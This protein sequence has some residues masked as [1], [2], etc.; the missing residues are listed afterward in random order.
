[1]IKQETSKPIS[2]SMSAFSMGKDAL[3]DR[4]VLV[5]GA[6]GGLGTEL[7]LACAR[8]GATVVLVSK[9]LYKQE[10]LYDAIE[11]IEGAPQPAIITINQA[12][13]PEEDYAQMNEILTSEFGHLDALVHTAA[14]VGPLSPL[15][16]IAQA[17][18]SRVMSVNLTSTRLLTNAC[19]PLL[20]LSSNASITFTMDEKSS[21]YWGAYGVSKMGLFALAS[22]VHDETENQ[23]ADDGAAQ[24][25]IN[26]IDPGPMRTPL[27]R[28]AFPGELETES[29]TPESKLGPFLALIARENRQLNGSYLKHP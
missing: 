29:P 10:L 25:A 15:T 20:N 7:C 2:D 17:D 9:T 22:I 27:R 24:I 8:S 16:Q 12:N 11:R 28:N 21:A 14:E 6:T 19:L 18:W 4:V 13:A 26:A 1:M 23:R 3:K 5:T